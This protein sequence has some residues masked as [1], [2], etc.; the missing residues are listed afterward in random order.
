[1][2]D[3][4][5]FSGI[6]FF[7][8]SFIFI[9]FLHLFKNILKRFISYKTVIFLSVVIY[10]AICIPHS[11]KLFLLLFYVYIIYIIFVSNNYQE[12]IFP[13]IVIAFPM[14]LHKVDIDPIFK[15]IGISYITF[16][17]I[18][19]I[20]DSQNYGKL[21][22]ME[23]TSFLLFPTTLLAGPIDRSYRFQEDLKKGYEN[24]TLQNVGKG[25]DI[26][27]VGVLFKFV[28]AQLVA[29]Y[30]LAKIDENSTNFLDMANSAYSYTTYLFFD[31]AGYSA[32]A[33]GLSFMIGIFI[34]MNFNHPYLA[35]N[36]QDFWRRF[37][38]TLGTWLTDYFFKPLYKYLHK[39][40]YLKNRKLILQNIAITCTFLLMGM[41]NGLTW[42]FIFS[43]FLFGIYSSIHNAY[44][45]YVKKGGY[46]YFSFFPEIISINL[47]R[48]LMINGAVF[49][50][51]FFSGRVP[52]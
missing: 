31:F 43:G 7:A 11:Y 46:D 28:I 50:L 10:I 39:Y 27:I 5:P 4:L 34:P 37:H 51:Y 12:T 32:M 38:I 3:F 45:L 33:V 20:V 30:W 22:F 29:M 35:P 18:Q 25:W 23:F 24:L 36:P 21:S 26:L 49:A 16:R 9:L 17:T 1:M 15:I 42:Y 19:A 2:E 8:I 52:L 41:W 40:P 47:K 6:G 48:F 13:M 44:V 14:I